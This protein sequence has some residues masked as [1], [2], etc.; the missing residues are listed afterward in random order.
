M[1]HKLSSASLCT[2]NL[3]CKDKISNSVV[4]AIWHFC[5]RTRAFSCTMKHEKSRVSSCTRKHSLRKEKFQSACAGRCDCLRKQSHRL[6]RVGVHSFECTRAFLC[7]QKS[8]HRP[9]RAD[10]TVCRNSRTDSQELVCTLL[11]ARESSRALKRVHTDSCE[12]VQ[13]FMQTV[14]SACTSQCAHF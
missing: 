14:A 12:P 11:S 8:A 6:A 4:L 13:L 10:A 3:S 2:R 7:T 1:K 5:M 9:M